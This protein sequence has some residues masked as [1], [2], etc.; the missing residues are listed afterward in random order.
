MYKNIF[1]ALILILIINL[2]GLSQTI[3][4]SY[5]PYDPSIDGSFIINGNL[6]TTVSGKY[7]QEGTSLYL[8]GSTDTLV[9]SSWV[10]DI[11]HKPLGIGEYSFQLELAGKFYPLADFKVD[12]DFLY[13][14]K[15]YNGTRVATSQFWA[16]G[17]KLSHWQIGQ[18][19]AVVTPINNVQIPRCANLMIR[20]RGNVSIKMVTV[21]TQ[22]S[23]S[24]NYYTRCIRTPLE[25]IKARFAQDY[26]VYITRFPHIQRTWGLAYLRRISHSR[27]IVDYYDSLSIAIQIE[28]ELLPPSMA[29]MLYDTSILAYND[30]GNL[31]YDYTLREVLF[32]YITARPSSNTHRFFGRMLEQIV[33]SGNKRCKLKNN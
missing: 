5:H 27:H 10:W 20:T 8:I 30:F 17:S 6:K 4:R 33:L 12:N 22:R 32:A 15:L 21:V 9:E 11:V 7:I 25:L 24:C 19:L 2:T 23:E 28:T 3:A 14:S 26:L 31:N 1:I 29:N 16:E 13:I 18:Y